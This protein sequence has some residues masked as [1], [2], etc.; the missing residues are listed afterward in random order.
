MVHH[1]DHFSLHGNGV[2]ESDDRTIPII[3]RETPHH[4]DHDTITQVLD[5]N[6]KVLRFEELLPGRPVGFKIYRDHVWIISCEGNAL[7]LPERKFRAKVFG[8]PSG[9]FP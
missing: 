3:K 1:F 9:P 4:E 5:G 6:P 8:G 7:F 2:I